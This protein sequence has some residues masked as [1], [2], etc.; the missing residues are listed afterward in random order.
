MQEE[1]IKTQLGQLIKTVLKQGIFVGICCEKLNNSKLDRE[2]KW[3][4]NV[5]RKG[6]NRRLN[7]CF[8]ANISKQF[9]RIVEK[10]F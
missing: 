4:I 10:Y 3:V 1:K 9:S 7:L 5:W 6:S 8:P 2:K